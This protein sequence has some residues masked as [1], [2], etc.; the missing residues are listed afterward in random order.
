VYEEGKIKKQPYDKAGK[1]CRWKDINNLMSFED[2]YEVL[3]KHPEYGGIQFIVFKMDGVCGI[4]YDH[5]I[6]AN[7]EI[8]A[9]VLVEIKELENPYTEISPS[10][11]GLRVLFY[12]TLPNQA[13]SKLKP[14][15]QLDN[16]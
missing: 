6:S 3:K 9:S 7:G 10:G 16:E 12:G 1:L 15:L 14:F 11:Q 4:D 5:V 13:V 8:E 2:A